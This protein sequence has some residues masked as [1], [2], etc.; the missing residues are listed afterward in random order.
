[1]DAVVYPDCPDSFPFFFNRLGVKRL[2]VFVQTHSHPE[3]GDL[4]CK[5]GGA[6]KVADVG[7][8]QSP[9]SSC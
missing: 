8:T 6:L 9:P 4:H 5:E 7:V 2:I 1:M 3:T